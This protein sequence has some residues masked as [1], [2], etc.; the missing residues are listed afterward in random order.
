MLDN[1]Q[2]LGC[3]THARRKFKDALDLSPKKNGTG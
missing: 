2:H 1:V 3:W